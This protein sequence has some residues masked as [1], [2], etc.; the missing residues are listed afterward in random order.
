MFK[1]QWG[2]PI[3]EGKAE[4]TGGKRLVSYQCNVPAKRGSEPQVLVK[5]PTCGHISTFIAAVL[6]MRMAPASSVQQKM[7]SLAGSTWRKEVR[8]LGLWLN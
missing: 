1:G 7:C 5:E 4:Y 8:G 3:G 6:R 2:R